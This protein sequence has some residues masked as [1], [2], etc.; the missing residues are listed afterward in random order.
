[1]KEDWIAIFKDYSCK[2]FTSAIS[3]NDVLYW[4]K[5]YENGRTWTAKSTGNIKNLRS[6]LIFDNELNPTELGNLKNSWK[7][8]A[9]EEIESNFLYQV[10]EILIKDVNGEQIKLTMEGSAQTWKVFLYPDCYFEALLIFM[11][12][13]NE[14]KNLNDLRTR[15]IKLSNYLITYKRIPEVFTLITNERYR[16]RHFE[17]INNLT[18][19]KILNVLTEFKL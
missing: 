19:N 12:A 15:N 16:E 6:F 13:L 10:L 5:R 3:S 11:I 14:F 18:K 8:M 2:V 17:S 4:I 9:V 1:M 7:F